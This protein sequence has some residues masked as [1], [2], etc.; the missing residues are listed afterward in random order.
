VPPL[1]RTKVL[2]LLV[3][4]IATQQQPILVGDVS[5]WNR[6]AALHLRD[7]SFAVSGDSAVSLGHSYSTLDWVPEATGSWVLPLFHERIR[8]L[9]KQQLAAS[10][11]Q[12][13]VRLGAIGN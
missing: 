10:P 7:R 11:S 8:H 12:F 9:L 4:Q 2:K 3:E 6:P 1:P 13:A 5:R